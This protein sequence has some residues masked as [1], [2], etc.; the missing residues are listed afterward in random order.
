MVY[1]VLGLGHLFFRAQEHAGDKS[2]YHR[3][4]KTRIHFES[5][6]KEYAFTHSQVLSGLHEKAKEFIENEVLTKSPV[7]VRHDVDDDPDHPVPD[8]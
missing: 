5:Y 6:H 7:V 4:L 2:L 3:L 8:L 1:W